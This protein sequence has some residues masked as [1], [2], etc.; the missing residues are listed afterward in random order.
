MTALNQ[1]YNFTESQEKH[2]LKLAK[3]DGCSSWEQYNCLKLY[4]EIVDN[5]RADFDEWKGDKDD[6]WWGEFLEETGWKEFHNTGYYYNHPT[7]MPRALSDI[8][9]FLEHCYVNKMTI[10]KEKEHNELAGNYEICKMMLMEK[11]EAD[12]E[13]CI[14]EGINQLTIS[15]GTGFYKEHKYKF[16][17]DVV[18]PHLTIHTDGDSKYSSYKNGYYYRKGDFPGYEV[19]WNKGDTLCFT[20][21]ESE[22]EESS[23]EE[24]DDRALQMSLMKRKLGLD[25]DTP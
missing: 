16:I 25:D 11:I 12:V 18:I 4:D 10:E 7:F 13:D 1:Y 2:D 20:R 14:Y 23:E 24:D 9:H 5:V 8:L 15:C 22:E 21:F 19:E 17:E 3:D 6:E